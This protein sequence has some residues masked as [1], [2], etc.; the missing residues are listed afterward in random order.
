MGSELGAVKDETIHLFAERG[1][2]VDADDPDALIV[3]GRKISVLT[4]F[5]S[6]A[7]I[8]TVKG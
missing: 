6:A 4:P 3:V 8:V 7:C 1:A 2:G 5:A